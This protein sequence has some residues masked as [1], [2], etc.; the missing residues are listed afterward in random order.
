MHEY[1]PLHSTNI[2]AL[3]GNQMVD[4]SGICVTPFHKI[5][6]LSIVRCNGAALA[7]GDRCNCVIARSAVTSSSNP[8]RPLQR[9]IAATALLGSQP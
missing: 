8:Q 3:L 5:R 6:R 9:S 4:F 2:P 1:S 7:C